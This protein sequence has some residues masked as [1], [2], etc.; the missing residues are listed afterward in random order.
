MKTL[1][2]ISNEIA[3]AKNNPISDFDINDFSEISGKQLLEDDQNQKNRVLNTK[4]AIKA[5]ESIGGNPKDFCSVNTAIW[6]ACLYADVTANE[7]ANYGL[8][9]K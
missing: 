9:F 3:N 4:K 2:T 6:E 7:A 1:T 5:I 8:S